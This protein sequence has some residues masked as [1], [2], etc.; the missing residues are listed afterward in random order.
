MGHDPHPMKI[1]LV[2][3]ASAGIGAATAR[4]LSREGWTLVL[5]ARRGERLREL[6][7]A[8]VVEADL[9]DPDA[10]ARIAETVEREH[11]RLDLL[12]NNAGAAW[13]ATFEEGGWEN[14]RRHMEL[15][16]DAQVRLTEALL[17]ILRR[18]APSAIVNVSSTSGRVARPR[19]GAY[20]AAKF[21]LAGWSD[22]LHLEEKPNGVHVGLV[23]PGFVA[24]EGFPQREL[25]EGR[26]TR[27][28][29]ASPEVVVDA[30][31]ETGPGGKAERYAPR[32]YWLAAALRVL[33]PSLV[34]RVLSRGGLSPDAS[35]H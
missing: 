27:H 29:V 6:G 22:S 11:G 13:R 15:D 25:V 24:T 8:T 23:L 5:V 26:L 33:A 28:F 21:A 3:G 32:Y 4:R 2:T 1:A 18:S 16:F 14:V 30:I 7:A 20:S 9:T 19:S 17:P 10:P 31:L 12:V 35:P 34:R